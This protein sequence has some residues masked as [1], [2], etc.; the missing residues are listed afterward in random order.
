MESKA[1]AI[2]CYESAIPSFVEKEMEQLYQNIFSS[3]LQFRTYG[4]ATETTSTYIARAGSDP[5]AIILFRH[6]KGRVHV[7]NE[8]IRIEAEEIRRFTNYIFQTY[9][10]VNVISFK[11]IQTDLDGFGFPHQQFN[12]S[13]DLVLTLPPTPQEYLAGL[14]KNTRRNVKRYGDRLTRS[15]PSFRFEVQENQAAD[16]VAVREIVRLN[17]ARMAG[18]KTVSVID[19]QEEER[20]VQRVKACGLV[21]VARID[22]KVCAGAISYRTGSNYF[23]DV[24]AHDPAY[25]DYWIGILCCYL[26]ICECIARGGKEFHFLWGRYD[27]KFTL[28]AVQ[29]DLDYVCIYR[30]RAQFLLNVDV[31]MKTAWHG[32]LRRAKL[33]HKYEAHRQSGVM[34]R[35]A[36]RTLAGAQALKRATSNLLP[37]S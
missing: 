14:G 32:Y 17:H 26:T 36:F 6:E 11:A 2:S 24:L 19:R 33:W 8:V 15:F 5:I 34:A 28:G 35:L 37:G 18:K 22:G 7:I 23:L 20:I 30:S 13:E 4:G 16:E 1:I 31:A 25:D 29:R 21:G 9:P 10:S 12:F 3:L 27:Y